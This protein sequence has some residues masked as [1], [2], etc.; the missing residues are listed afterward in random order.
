MGRKKLSEA[1]LEERGFRSL[2]SSDEVICT[3]CHPIS[4]PMTRG[5]MGEHENYKKHRDGMSERARD[6]A[7]ATFQSSWAAS[8]KNRVLDYQIPCAYA[9]RTTQPALYEA[10][11][12]A[13]SA[14][15]AVASQ[16]LPLP[17]A[18]DHSVDTFIDDGPLPQENLMTEEERTVYLDN[19]ERIREEMDI[20]GEIMEGSGSVNHS[21]SRGWVRDEASRRVELPQG[22]N[23]NYEPWG[24][25][26]M[27][28]LHSMDG[29]PRIRFSRSQ[30]ES[31][32]D[33]LRNLGHTDVP[34]WSSFRRQRKK[35][36]QKC[37]FASEI[38]KYPEID[39]PAVSEDWETEWWRSWPE[40]LL[41][42]MWVHPDTKKHFYVKEVALCRN[43][44]YL[45]PCKWV[46]KGGVVH[47][48][49]Q[50]LTH[51]EGYRNCCFSLYDQDEVLIRAEDLE[52]PMTELD[53]VWLYDGKDGMC[54]V[55]LNETRIKANGNEIYTIFLPL[56]I[57]DVSGN[58]SNLFNKHINVYTHMAN[59]PHRLLNQEFFVM[60]LSTSQF[61]N[62]AE[63]ADKIVERI[64]WVSIFILAQR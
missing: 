25:K 43:S 29:F 10:S 64:K 27:F 42:P 37:C 51:A 41:N 54:L 30:W 46:T 21:R 48:S 63:Q 17:S 40:H 13:Y 11:K 59:L 31:V 18:D 3:V 28:L 8:F 38:R 1:Q 34:S 39:P 45:I 15:G 32:F 53:E 55:E 26:I 57:D 20:E 5:R 4:A 44:D 6:H 22:N 2:P 16:P 23:D 56:W 58:I 14:I 35:I 36:L 19:L 12:E 49:C 33:L 62:F 61:A 60:P 24:S 50:V 9:P 52:L 7:Q 47:T